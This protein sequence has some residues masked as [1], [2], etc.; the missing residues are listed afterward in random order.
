M[1]VRV[2][3]EAFDPAAALSMFTRAQVEAGGIASFLGVCRATSVRGAI[4][5]L[6]LEHFE[7]FTEAEIARI[8]HDARARFAVLDTLIMHRAGRILPGEPIVLVAAAAAH[9]RAAFDA[10]DFLMDYLKTEAPFWKKEETAAGAT[11][12]EPRPQD[13]VDVTRWSDEREA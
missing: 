7:G 10:V 1:A 3:L 6:T 9:R 12:I 5:S 11:W 2:F 4:L 13:T 8:D